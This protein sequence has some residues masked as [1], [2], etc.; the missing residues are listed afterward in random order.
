MACG[1]LFGREKDQPEDKTMNSTTYSEFEDWL[2]RPSALRLAV[3]LWI[4]GL[5]L[6]VAV[7]ARV[8]RTAP[9]PASTFTSSMGTEA[10]GVPVDSAA[11]ASVVVLPEDV[12]V[13]H[14]KASPGVTLRQK[15]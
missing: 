15:P 7:G 13:G 11:P 9:G 5:A 12:V 14:R 10:H 6:A 2:P 4:A 3:A 1:L 8:Q